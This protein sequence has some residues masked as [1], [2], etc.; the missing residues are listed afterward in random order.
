MSTTTPKDALI[1]CFL[2]HGKGSEAVVALHEEKNISSANVSSGRGLGTVGRVSFGMW[3]EFDILTVMVPKEL[4]E[5]I[6]TYIYETADMH[7]PH[8]GLIFSHGLERTT[9]FIL[10]KDVEEENAS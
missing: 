4:E 9:D 8:G 2:P 6:F 3:S 10:P 5:E 1:T 7:R